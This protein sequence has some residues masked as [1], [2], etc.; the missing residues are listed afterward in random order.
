MAAPV[1]QKIRWRW[2]AP[3][4]VNETPT[5]IVEAVVEINDARKKQDGEPRVIDSL[6][7]VIGE[8]KPIAVL[9]LTFKP[10]TDDMRDCAFAGY[11]SGVASGRR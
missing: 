4:K 10:N 6:R 2:C 9:G 1:F 5:K 11:C 3:H 8:A 7:R